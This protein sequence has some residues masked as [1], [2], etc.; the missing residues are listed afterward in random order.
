MSFLDQVKIF[1]RVA[2]LSSFSKA[3]TTLGMPKASISTSVQ[4]L[5]NRLGTQLLHRTTRK[6]Q[7]THDGQ[8]FYERGIDA[9]ADMDELQSLFQAKGKSSLQ[10]R[11]RIGLTSSMARNCVI[12][13][14]PELLAVHPDI[15]LE[16]SGTERRVDFIS[17]GFDCVLR[18]GE[19]GDP[20]LIS[21]T[22]AQLKMANVASPDYLEKYGTP[23]SVTDL[24]EHRMVHFASNFGAKPY[25]FEYLRDEE[26][27]AIPMG[28][29]MTV[30]NADAYQAACLAG[31]G[32]IQVPLIGVSDL[33]NRGDLVEILPKDLARPMPLTLLYA[34]KRN[35]SVRVR[36]V[37]DWLVEVVLEYVNE[38]Q[39]A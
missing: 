16:V 20:S 26:E 21:R 13:R 32:I 28:G 24:A 5:E 14:L 33:I 18:T 27:L 39:A 38:R 12:P 6:V 15:E 36:V 1:A 23:Q 7:L 11:V 22:V 4:Q 29:A 2:E 34:N 30:N 3:A 31:L 25:G 10:G 9:L 17:E 19:I 8:V 35:L 37:M